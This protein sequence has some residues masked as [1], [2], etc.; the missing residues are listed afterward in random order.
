MTKLKSKNKV[1]VVTNYPRMVINVQVMPMPLWMAA[2]CDTRELDFHLAHYCEHK[3]PYGEPVIIA[4]AAWYQR[5]APT[6]TYKGFSVISTEWQLITM[7]PKYDENGY[8]VLVM[9]PGDPVPIP[10]VRYN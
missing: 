3:M 7:V 1:T 8:P 2:L 5:H 4:G 9:V 10:T 6:G